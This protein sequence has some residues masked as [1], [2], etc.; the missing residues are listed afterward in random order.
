VTRRIT[1]AWPDPVPFRDRAGA[2]LRILAVSDDREPAFDHE[3][4]RQGLGEIDFI[5]A[6]GDLERDYLSFLGDAFGAPVLYVRGNHDRGA[7]WVAARGDSPEPLP[8][9]TIVEEHGLRLIGLSWAGN[10]VGRAGRDE[11]GA[12]LQAARTVVTVLRHGRRPT[13]V[14]SHAPPRG[15]GDDPSDHYHRGFAGYRWLARWLRPPLWLHG[16]TTVA[17]VTST[18]VRLDGTLLINVTG[19]VLVTL[20]PPSDTATGPG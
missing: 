3:R 9:A 10:A 13:L 20:E 8:D 17:T 2:P 1:I 5:V 14:L 15:A 16:H 19:S 4:N 12:W 6:C 7:A 11:L 18:D